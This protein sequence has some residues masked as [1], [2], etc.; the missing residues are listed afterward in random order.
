M[1]RVALGRH[2]VRQSRTA[3]L[4]ARW[5]AG[6]AAAVYPTTDAARQPTAVLPP[7]PAKRTFVA[8]AQLQ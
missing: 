7:C 6:G 1:L 5:E 3:V 2:R 4:S 8:A